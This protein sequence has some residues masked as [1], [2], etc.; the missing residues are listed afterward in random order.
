MEAGLTSPLPSEVSTMAV[1]SIQGAVEK[2][3]PS[4]PQEETAKPQRNTWSSSMRRSM[5]RTSTA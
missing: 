4:S 1:Y 5:P 3:M 2:P